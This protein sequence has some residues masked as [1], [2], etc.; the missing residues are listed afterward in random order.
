MD[1]I[2]FQQVINGIMLGRAYGVAAVGFTLLFGVL[3]VFNFA[4]GEVVMIGAFLS[5][6]L[7]RLGLPFPVAVLGT[8]MGGGVLSLVI[9]RGCFRPFR[10]SSAMVPMLSTIGMAI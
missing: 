3:Q 1:E 10:Q 7:V 9:E 6:G 4:H 2:F 8:A 5:L